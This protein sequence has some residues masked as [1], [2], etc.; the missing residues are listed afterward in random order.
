M[1]KSMKPI[2]NR[3]IAGVALLTAAGLAALSLA[4]PPK[5]SVW[6]QEMVVQTCEAGTTIVPLQIHNGTSR[7]IQVVGVHSSCGCYS[8]RE[9]LPFSVP[10][11]ADS[12]VRLIV[13]CRP[14]PGSRE[15]F[16]IYVSDEKLITFNIGVSR[17]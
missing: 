6:P 11:G 4:T 14:Q 8:L 10:G 2:V 1:H 16:T 13:P 15:S 17:R 12:T 7:P 5:V 3:P 9:E